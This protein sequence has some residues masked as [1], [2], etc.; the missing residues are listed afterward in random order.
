MRKL[1]ALFS[2]PVSPALAQTPAGVINAPIYATGY[3]SQVGG[4]NVTTNIPPQPN[5]PTNLNIYTTGSISGTWTIK[6]PNPAF[7]GQIL[8]FNCG[9]AANAISVISSDG[10][11]IDS[12]LPTSCSINSGFTTQFDQRSNIWRNISSNNTSTFKPFTGVTSQWPWQLNTDGTWTLKRPDAGDV[13]FTQTGTGAVSRTVQAKGQ[14]RVTF[15]DFGA[16]GDGATMND[17]AW[18][19]FVAACASATKT[20]YVPSGTYC[21]A[22]TASYAGTAITLVGDGRS[23]TNFQLCSGSTPRATLDFSRGSYQGTGIALKGFSV[24]APPNVSSALATGISIYN[25]GG[26]IIDD[27]GVIG[28][29]IGLYLGQSFAAHITNSFFY[30]NGCNAILFESDNS[31]NAAYVSHNHILSNGNTNSCF[32]IAAVGGYAGQIVNNNIESNYGGVVLNGTNSARVVG[33]EWELAGINGFLYFNGT[34]YNPVVDSNAFITSSGTTSWANVVGGSFTDNLVDNWALTLASSSTM[35]VGANATLGFGS[36][37]NNETGAVVSTTPPIFTALTG[38]VFCNG[39]SACSAATTAIPGQYGGTGVANTGKTITVGANL[40]TSGGATTLAFGATGRTYTFPDTTGTVPLLGLAQTWSANQTFNSGNF[41][42]AGSTSGTLTVKPAATAG[43]NTLTLPAGTTDFSATGGTNQVVQQTSVG[44]A[45]TVGQLS[46]AAL[47]AG[48]LANGM[49]ATTQTAA[50]NSTKLA[51]TAYVDSAISTT[52]LT[53]TTCTLTW[54]G[55]P[56]TAPTC[57][58]SYEQIGKML[59]MNITVFTGTALNGATAVSVTLPNSKSLLGAITITGAY[60]GGTNP[61]WLYGAAANATTMGL[62][63]GVGGASFSANNYVNIN[64]WV[65]VN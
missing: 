55:G 59:Y 27:I 25:R 26:A 11:T 1:L 33:N 43:S 57:N 36:I 18:T 58:I 35:K 40:T 15:T 2:V 52:G 12:T 60:A 28:N 41:L 23:T 30:N 61:A 31:F 54:T 10:S 20:C 7:E 49:T 50:D 13:T 3:I 22:N 47:S 48:A 29:Y 44:G 46:G 62:Y 63:M 45:F 8:S 17:T 16:V 42:L 37:T 39:A 9:A 4:T 21:F 64:G 65:P 24:L 6:L 34:N 19:N 53:S 51:T 32:A 5:H 14:E 56:P 38:Y